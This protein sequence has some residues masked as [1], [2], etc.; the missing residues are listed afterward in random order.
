M[1]GLSV[2]R[3]RRFKTSFYFLGPT[4]PPAHAEM[5]SVKRYGGEQRTVSK[6]S[7]RIREIAREVFGVPWMDAQWQKDDGLSQAIPPAYTEFIGR[8]LI[9]AISC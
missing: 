9:Q 5:F 7:R 8:Q 3:H 4:E 6:T 2:H 1:F